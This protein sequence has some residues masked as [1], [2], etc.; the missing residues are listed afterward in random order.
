MK[1]HH[2]LRHTMSAL[3]AIAMA[4]PNG[5]FAETLPCQGRYHVVSGSVTLAAEG[6]VHVLTRRRNE[7]TVDLTYQG[8][9]RILMA[10][11]AYAWTWSARP[12]RA[13]PRG[14][15]EAVRRGSSISAP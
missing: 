15:T 11:V 10:G 5:G 8:C 2:F 6:R 13:G 14:W 7:G 1:R 3:T 12:P 9:D 4:A